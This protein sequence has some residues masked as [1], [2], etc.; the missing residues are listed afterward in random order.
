MTI[1]RSI[2]AYS[3]TGSGI[4]CTEGTPSLTLDCCDIYG[5]A[6]GDWVGCIADWAG[7][8]GNFSLDP[9]FS[10]TMAGNYGVNLDSPCAPANNPCAALIG[11]HGFCDCSRIGDCDGD[12]DISVVDII[13]LIDHTLRSGSPL[14]ADPYCPVSNR[15]DFNCDGYINLIDLV[16]LINYVYRYPAPGPCDPCKL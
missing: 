14:P 13:Y 1:E 4:A 2:I 8:N 9:M 15:G 3:S 7:I 16:G 5:N 6:G 11:A 12:G 10:D